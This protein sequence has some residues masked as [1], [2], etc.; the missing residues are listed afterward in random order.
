MAISVRQKKISEQ[1]K[2]LIIEQLMFELL[3]DNPIKN[4]FSIVKTQVSADLK[5][6]HMYISVDNSD[7]RIKTL[8]KD[9]LNALSPEIRS[10]LGKKM[11]VKSVPNVKFL[12][13][14]DKKMI[15]FDLNNIKPIS[16]E[17]I[18]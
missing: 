6:I 15:Q 5:N 14:I 9:S 16:A 1:V 7:D 4:M 13:D 10:M 17:D 11:V 8:I 3:I 18:L 2:R 12:F